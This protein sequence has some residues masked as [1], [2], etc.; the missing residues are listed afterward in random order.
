MRDAA[1]LVYDQCVTDPIAPSSPRLAGRLLIVAYFYPPMSGGGIPRPV[2]MAKYLERCGWQVSVLT[3]AADAAGT[4]DPLLVVAPDATSRVREWKLGLLLRGAGHAYRALRSVS[5]V[6]RVK[7]ARNSLLDMGFAY[8]EQEIEASKVG[9]VMPAFRAAMRIHRRNPIDVVIV[10]T[11]PASSGAVGWLLNLFRRIPYVVE[12]RDPWTVEAFWTTDADGHRRSDIATR[13]R[14]RVTRC[15]ES[16]LL[17]RS[18]GAVIVNGDQH[19]AAIREE[20][21]HQLRNKPVV[22]IRNGVDLEDIRRIEPSSPAC[23]RLSL[24]HTGFFYHFHSPHQVV[25]ALR[26]LKAD[27]RIGNGEM[28]VT[29]IGGGFPDRLHQAARAWDLDDTVE[30]EGP[31]SYS[32]SLQAMCDADGLLLVLAPLAS[33]RE[34]IPTKLYEYLGTGKPILAVVDGEGAVARLL[35]SVPRALVADNR[36]TALVADAIQKFAG[37]MRAARADHA[38]KGLHGADYDYALR[39]AEMDDLLRVVMDASRTKRGVQ[40]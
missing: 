32:G 4:A 37:I 26:Q 33:Y 25:E 9:W 11:P 17:S 10:S 1:V 20:F 28:A 21:G 7:A 31:R 18:A 39:A 30:V 34:C 19:V 24:V 15:M 36:D 14:Y 40:L 27:G 13:L 3:I 23:D 16:L 22:H 2:K 5:T 35:S 8:E 29:F 12:Y 6:M 38:G